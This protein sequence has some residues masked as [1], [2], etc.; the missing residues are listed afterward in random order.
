MPHRNPQHDYILY[1]DSLKEY[2]W[3]PLKG[4][5]CRSEVYLL[6]TYLTAHD[7]GSS[8]LG[9]TVKSGAY[10]GGGEGGIAPPPLPPPKLTPAGL[11]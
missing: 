5:H 8:D 3:S 7:R 10:P 6:G 11:N 2:T 1:T 9:R 4:W